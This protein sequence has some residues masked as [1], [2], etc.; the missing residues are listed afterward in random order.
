[1]PLKPRRICCASLTNM[2]WSPPS[3][4]DMPQPTG[5]PSVLNRVKRFSHSLGS[6]KVE[7]PSAYGLCEAHRARLSRWHDQQACRWCC[8]LVHVLAVP[9]MQANAERPHSLIRAQFCVRS[10]TQFAPPC[11]SS[12]ARYV[13]HPSRT[14]H[15]AWRAFWNLPQDQP[16]C[17]PCSIGHSASGAQGARL[18]RRHDQHLT[19]ID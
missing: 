8:H 6:F 9:C 19:L 1:M 18:T 4:L 13:V 15:A 7:A 11:R 17:Q 2:T 16:T 10:S 12:R 5:L 14:R 3:H